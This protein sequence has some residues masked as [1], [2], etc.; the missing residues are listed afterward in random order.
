MKQ[1]VGVVTL[2][3]NSLAASCQSGHDSHPSFALPSGCLPTD[4]TPSMISL[5]PTEI[6][7]KALAREIEFAE[8][9]QSV[10]TC[11]VLIEKIFR[12]ARR[13]NHHY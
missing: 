7:P 3:E 5:F 12:F 1:W 11:P 2:A 10:S 8:A 9:I 6:Q 13:A 4:A